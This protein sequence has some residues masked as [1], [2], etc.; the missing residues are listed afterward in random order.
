MVFDEGASD[1]NCFIG[2]SAPAGNLSDFFVTFD[3]S[4]CD[5]IVFMSSLESSDHSS[6]SAKPSDYSSSFVELSS[7]FSPSFRSANISEPAVG[8]KSAE[9]VV[10]M[11][12]RVTPFRFTAMVI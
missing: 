5:F 8:C 11:A 6:S 4:S 7:G 1:G 2:S 10:E 3:R 9:D 12:E